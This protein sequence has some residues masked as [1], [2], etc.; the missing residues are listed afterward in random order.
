M[1]HQ[2]HSHRD[3]GGA[4]Q[5]VFIQGSVQLLQLCV[6]LDIYCIF[7]YHFCVHNIHI[8][9]H[10]HIFLHMYIFT[11][12][13]IHIFLHMCVYTNICIYV[14][15][16]LCIYVYMYICIY[17]YMYICIYIYTLSII[18]KIILWTRSHGAPAPHHLTQP[19]IATRLIGR[20]ICVV[21]CLA[22]TGAK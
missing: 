12:Y 21:I 4:P 18:S 17:V 3:H 6:Y 20:Q 15:M 5:D 2:N 16:Y 10:I 9:I 1:L 8:N 13:Y 7:A 11:Y 14:F 19:E 22:G